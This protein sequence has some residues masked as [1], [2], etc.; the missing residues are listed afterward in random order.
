MSDGR[1]DNIG[2]D[3]SENTWWADDDI[4]SAIVELENALSWLHHHEEEL[5]ISQRRVVEARRTLEESMNT[6]NKLLDK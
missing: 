1:S 5:L 6:R 3:Y 4:K 2:I